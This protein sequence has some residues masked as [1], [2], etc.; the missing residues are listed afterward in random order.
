GGP[1]FQPCVPSMFQ[2]KYMFPSDAV[3]AIS[4]LPAERTMAGVEK[5]DSPATVIVDLPQMLFWPS[6]FQKNSIPPPNVSA[7]IS[8]LPA[9][10]TMAGAE[11]MVPDVLGTISPVQFLVPSGFQRS[12]RL[13]FVAV[14][15]T[16]VLLAERTIA[17]P[18]VKPIPITFAGQA[19]GPLVPSAF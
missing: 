18:R 8:V 15:A 1:G 12:H 13:W 2:K 5:K 10:R 4:V 19:P 11:S 6:I 16:S 9:E 14:A 17:G 3:A 7:A